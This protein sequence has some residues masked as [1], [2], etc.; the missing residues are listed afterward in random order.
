[1]ASFTDLVAE[2]IR[3]RKEEFL[4]G[5]SSKPGDEIEQLLAQAIQSHWHP[6]ELEKIRGA[7][8][9]RSL[10]AAID[11]SSA[12]RALNSGADWVIAQALLIGPNGLRRS[13]V[14]THLL[15][16]ETERP[17]VA[18]YAALMM[19]SL[20][21]DLALKFVESGEG[22][23][24]ILDGSLYANLPYLL[25][26][27]AIRGYED[28]PL[29]VLEQYLELFDLCQ[30]RGVLLLG[31]SK[32]ARSA[33]LGHALL[34]EHSTSQSLIAQQPASGTPEPLDADVQENEEVA[35]GDA[36]NGK[37]RRRGVRSGMNGIPTDGE[38]MHRWTKGAGLTDPVLLGSSSFG[39]AGVIADEKLTLQIEE[40]LR[41]PQVSPDLQALLRRLSYAPAIGTFYVRL[42]PGDEVLRV[43]ALAS[44]FGRDD[45]HLLGF[46]RMLVPFTTALPHVQ[47]LLGE[48]GGLSVYNAALY[49]VDKEVR[50][51]AAT[52]DH[53]Y[54]PVLRRQLGQ[55]VEYDRSTRRFIR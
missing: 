2:R 13:D 25:Y 41:E 23:I 53:V 27:L 22:H 14:E 17:A 45:L 37:G 51:H 9:S 5:L 42:A 12:I 3:L 19:R 10:A 40:A 15:R 52:V 54:L 20:E 7:D 18:R 24:L 43:D 47:Y 48:Y 49:V 16:G 21:L 29:Q 32:S 33:V 26:R 46:T 31:I 8:Q 44:T 6:F 39:R 11:G 55:T 1:M 38:I 30:K 36:V 50:L 4:A 35:P 34:D 28:V